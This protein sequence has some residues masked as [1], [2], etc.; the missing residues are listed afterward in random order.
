MVQDFSYDL[1]LMDCLMPE[2][3]GY[4]ATLAIRQIEHENGTERVPI[5]A[6]TANAMQGERERCLNVGMDDF[7][8]KP[9]DKNDLL[10]VVLRWT[11]P[12]TK[13]AQE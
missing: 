7:L 5:I 4:D 3:D 8:S 13:I 6:L 1:I 10:A 9:F 12:R 11:P 2:M